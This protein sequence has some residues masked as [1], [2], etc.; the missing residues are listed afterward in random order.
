MINEP[1]YTRFCTMLHGCNLQIEINATAIAG[2][3]PEHQR[4]DYTICMAKTGTDQ[5]LFTILQSGSRHFFHSNRSGQ[6]KREEIGLG[7]AVLRRFC[8][9]NPHG[10]RGRTP[11]GPG[12]LAALEGPATGAC[13]GTILIGNRIRKARGPGAF[14]VR[15]RILQADIGTC[16]CTCKGQGGC[17]WMHMPVMA[18]AQLF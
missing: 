1:R 6:K 5:R 12:L 10:L 8:H 14:G 13:P 17:W 9:R 11:P 4:H 3:A 15:V 2:A 7:G 16:D 18:G